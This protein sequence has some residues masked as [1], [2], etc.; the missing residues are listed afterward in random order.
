MDS[1]KILLDDPKKAVINVSKPIIVATFIES[2]YSLVDSIW[3]SG[4]GYNALAAIGASFPI[5]ISVYAISWGLSIGISSGISRKIGERNKEEAN[6]VANHG[7]VLAIIMG[8]L[9]IILV[10]PNLN[11]I[12]S[13]MGTYG[14]C[15]T[16]AVEY[17]KILVLGVIIINLCDA[18]YGIFRG[19]GNTKI[20]MIASIV[21]TVS[22]II[23]DPIYI[24]KLNLGIIG[25][26]I[27]TIL[28][29]FIAL[30]IL[31]YKLFI[32]KSSYITVNLKNFKPDLKIISD[33]I[34]VG[35][36]TS[37]IDLTVAVSFFIMTSLIML[38]G[39]SKD[40][41][42]YTGALR[43][44]EFGFIPML[45]LASGATS[46]LGASY[47]AK[48]FKKLKTAYFYTIKIGVLMEIV[49]VSLIVL[50][51][52]IL[53]YLF[54]YTKISMGIHEE[55]VKALRIIPLYLIFTP[56]ILTTSALFQGIGKGE[57]SLIIAIFRSL[58]CHISYAYIFA[59]ILGLGIFGIY[60]SLVFGDFT[61]GIFSLIFG[62]IAI[63]SMLKL[64]GE[65]R[66]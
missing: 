33:L 61:S 50:F 39:D 46:V 38:V 58:V 40:L 34:R 15:K 19:E 48:E 10:Y 6:K 35:L 44:T 14:L 29:V 7:I 21:G 5:L 55:L 13:L 57:K 53:A 62:I 18:L 54:T 23:L 66:S 47:G 42:V 9:F 2:I 24:Y 36:P 11:S 25:A 8:I 16:L 37:F 56:F 26:S 12:F 43:I 4:L 65:Y 27:A 52:P 20:V 22:N 30:L 32:K 31:S 41:A 3:V 17:S 49:I 45:G 60:I 51:S 28:S 1:V 59:V 63:N 64:E